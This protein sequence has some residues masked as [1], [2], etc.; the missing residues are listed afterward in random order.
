MDKTSVIFGNQLDKKTIKAAAKGKA[1]YVKKFGDDSKK[2]YHLAATPVKTLSFMGVNN[3]VLS[4]K[5]L[6][7]PENAVIIGNIRM[8]FGHYRISMAMA[9]AAKA[10]GYEPYWF[11]LASFDAAGSKVIRSQN[12]L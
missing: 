9:S 4:D 12:D 10:L 7:L 8:G 2:E 6:K 11:D 3:L 5:P 1:K